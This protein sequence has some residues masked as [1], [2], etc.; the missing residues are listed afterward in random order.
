MTITSEDRER[1][2]QTTS[3]FQPQAEED[4]CL[5]TALK[6]VLDNLSERVD[7]PRLSLS[8]SRLNDICD[9]R[10]DMGASARRV[11]NRLNPEISSTGYQ[12]KIGTRLE[13]DDLQT[14]IEDEQSS[15]P[16]V[17]L[18]SEYFNSVEGYNAT[19]G[20]DGYQFNHVV[21]PFKVNT[22]KVLFYDP[23]EAIF[24]RSSNINVPPTKRD[25]AQFYEWWS[26]TE[27]GRW[28]MWI[29]QRDQTLLGQSQFG[30]V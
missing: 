3:R 23:F 7:Q 28:T 26:R 11:P 16:I 25:K 30:G 8:Q 27:G 2:D 5:P 29:V 13:W 24:T 1:F 18:D 10:Q 20:P 21:I 22:Q 19:A 9:Y 15:L 14:I 17:E 12:V 6:N 4:A